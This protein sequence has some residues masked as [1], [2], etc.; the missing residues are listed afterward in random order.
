MTLLR[1]ADRMLNQPLLIHPAKI[2]VI[3]YAL[4]SRLNIAADE[5]APELSRFMGTRRRD[6]RPH[7][8]SRAAEGVAL[9]DVT[10]S[11]VNR[12]AWIG[13]SS[14]L[15][16]YE[17]LAA[18]I[19][20]AVADPEIKGVV[21]DIDSP[22]GEASGMYG[23]ADAIRTAS[24]KKPVLAVVNDMAASAAY[25]LASAAGEI[26]ISQSS[27]VGSIGVVV[28]HM[29]HSV[30]LANAGVR[31]TI[32]K[33][34][35]KKLLANA[36][37]PLSETARDYLSGMVATHYERFLE[38]VAAGRSER[39][40][41]AAARA[42]E[43]GV[44]IGADAIKAGLADRIGTIEQAVAQIARRGAGTA[45]HVIHGGI[46][47]DENSGNA[48]TA[49]AGITADQTR[50]AVIEATAKGRETERTRIGAIMRCD[51]AQGREAQAL[52][53]ALDTSLEPDAAKALLATFP[54]ASAQKAAAISSL[55][56]RMAGQ[57]QEPV[58][59]PGPVTTPATKGGD[60]GD[61]YAEIGAKT[62][63]ARR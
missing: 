35:S 63:M 46:R 28:V 59:N 39:L 7:G 24:G 62:G 31:P 29:D 27:L 25:G 19:A 61:I 11:L 20:D 12:G 23:L 8:L 43:A 49:N 57:R 5:P 26:W 58:G 40:T 45:S 22:G 18:Q 33:A 10:G 30:E 44:Y 51:E 14:G 37:E 42:T 13:A 36:L 15:T 9:I 56:E 16:S 21:L 2:N 54:K 48:P 41:V 34:G 52:T 60:W 53:I 17:G 6:A 1:I 3:L 50:A 4:H 55:D 38:T 32:I 47:M